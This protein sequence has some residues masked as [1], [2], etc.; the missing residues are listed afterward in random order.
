MS[1]EGL[2]RKIFDESDRDKNGFIDANELE[3]LLTQINTDFDGKQ[4]PAQIKKF[5][6]DYMK[7]LDKN[8]D[9]KLSFDEF[10]EYV[11]KAF[12]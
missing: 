9:N 2:A 5:A 11:K 3:A 12:Q 6:Q 8:N 7:T 10:L 4:T 1:L